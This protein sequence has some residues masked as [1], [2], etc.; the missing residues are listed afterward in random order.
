MA[1]VKRVSISSSLNLYKKSM[2]AT[3]EI[4]HRKV[5]FLP[6]YPG[7]AEVLAKYRLEDGGT[8]FGCP[9]YVSLG[10]NGHYFIRSNSN[11]AWDLPRDIIEQP[12]WQGDKI[13]A[14]WLGM[15]DA[16]V[17]QLKN[18]ATRKDL[19]GQYSNSGH[20]LREKIQT[21]FGTKRPGQRIKVCIVF[22]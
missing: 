9:R 19:K 12:W 1:L 18:G 10:V 15:N 16:W 14:V 3:N 13:K 21:G 17:V 7:L 2:L 8:S 22:A 6:D 20:L 4:H 11:S 5:S